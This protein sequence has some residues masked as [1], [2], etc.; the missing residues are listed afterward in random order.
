L[1][2]YDPL[3]TVCD[4]CFESSCWQGEFMC[5]QAYSA[6][7]T[8]RHVSNLISRNPGNHE[9]PDWWNKDLDMKNQR[10]LTRADLERLGV[11]SP[12]YL[13]LST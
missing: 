7:I 11:S 8:D 5:S 12:E 2:Q 13:L 3:I 6:G 4:K 10:L 1:N 9:H